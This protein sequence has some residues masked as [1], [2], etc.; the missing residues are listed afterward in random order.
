MIRKLFPVLITF[1]CSF[2]SSQ[3]ALADN[4]LPSCSPNCAYSD[5]SAE[6]VIFP[7]TVYTTWTGDL[8]D[9][10]YGDY[11]FN[12]WY[13]T[14]SFDYADSAVD[15]IV[16]LSFYAYALSDY[17]WNGTMRHAQNAAGMIWSNW[18][19]GMPGWSEDAN[20]VITFDADPPSATPEPSTWLLLGSG[21]IG[22]AMLIKRY[23]I[24]QKELSRF[25]NGF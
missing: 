4:V 2:V 10:P 20:G 17:D 19:N 9:V 12:L 8:A 24:F 18:A 5:A 3:S 22:L 7:A 16:N 14:P 25:A 11:R 23:L 6:P 1:C 15:G 21:L 13:G